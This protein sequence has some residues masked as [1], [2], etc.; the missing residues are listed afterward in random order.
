MSENFGSLGNLDNLTD[1]D[2]PRDLSSPR[3]VVIAVENVSFSWPGQSTP[4]LQL[5]ALNVERQD[6]I[7]IA[8]PSG[9]G[10]STL[11]ALIGGIVVPQTGT[12]TILGS[13]LH[14][15]SASSRD[16]FRVDHI[17]FIFQQFNLIPYLSILDNV[18]LPCHFSR[19][20][21]QRAL[22]Q[23][24]TLRLAAESLLVSLDLAPLL[25]PKPVTQ[26]SIGQQQRVAAARALIGQPEIIVADEP[27]SA[28]DADRQQRFLDL[29]QRECEQA[30][31]T[32]LFVSH[33][34]RLAARFSHRLALNELNHAAQLEDQ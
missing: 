23:G 31:S 27:T 9:S 1:R 24:A 4:T 19:Y 11:L 16:Q 3:E 29:I 25:W 26:L 34:E 33:D 20:R 13:E 22:A 30:H 14:S 10:K 18:L 8:G 17:G 21:R 32:L 6:Q 5:D 12:I 7:F 15:L 28:L 2:N